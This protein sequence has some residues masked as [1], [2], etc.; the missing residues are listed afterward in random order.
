VGRG[1]KANFLAAL[2]LVFPIPEWLTKPF[3]FV[4]CWR[5]CPLFFPF[6]LGSPRL[7]ASFRRPAASA[8]YPS[9]VRCT[10]SFVVRCLSAASCLGGLL[11]CVRQ[12]RVSSTLML[13]TLSPNALHAL[14]DPTVFR[15]HFFPMTLPS[16]VCTMS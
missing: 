14:S 10:L 4:V 6:S 12:P 16:D 15:E 1:A 11:D 13:G 9:S 5:V 8:L 7:R 3:Q 2:R